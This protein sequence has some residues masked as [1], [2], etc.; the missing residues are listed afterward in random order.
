MSD[1]RPAV[2]VETSVVSYLAARPSRDPVT[3][4]RQELTRRWWS[5]APT[6]YDRFAS[7]VVQR[8]CDRGD[9]TYAAARAAIIASLP[10]LAGGEEA[11]ELGERLVRAGLIPPKAAGDALHIAV[12][13]MNGMDFLIT[14]NF[15]HL[16]NGH[17]RRQVGRLVRSAG[18]EPPT[19]VTPQELGGGLDDDPAR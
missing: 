8:E 16:A 15:A 11:D 2:Y 14:W 1:T 7:A 4:A 6:R 13:T 17:V 12:A 9:P 18:L 19:I 10:V 3:R 5:A